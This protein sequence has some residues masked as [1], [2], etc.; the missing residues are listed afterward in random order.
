MNAYKYQKGRK[1]KQTEHST[2]LGITAPRVFS[3]LDSYAVKDFVF[4]FLLL[5]DFPHQI[6]Y[7]EIWKLRGTLKHPH[8]KNFLYLTRALKQN[9]CLVE[10]LISSE[11]PCEFS[12]EVY[13]WGP[14][15]KVTIQCGKTHNNNFINKYQIEHIQSWKLWLCLK[16]NWMK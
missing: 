11:L 6:V 16:P 7:N 12:L 1:T 15:N 14:K 8:I 4:F 2:A 3:Q 13:T 9:A 10:Y 5:C